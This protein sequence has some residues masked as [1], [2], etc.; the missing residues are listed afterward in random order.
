[1]PS[2]PLVGAVETAEQ[3]ALKSSAGAEPSV[4]SR[5]DDRIVTE[6]PGYTLIYHHVLRSFQEMY[7]CIT[8]NFFYSLYIHD[9]GCLCMRKHLMLMFCSWYREDG[10]ISLCLL[11]FECCLIEYC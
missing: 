9:F 1:M 8:Y 5:A 6:G 4:D 2:D 10:R 11:N 3:A 7:K